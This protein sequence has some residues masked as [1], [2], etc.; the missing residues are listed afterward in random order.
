MIALS[1]VVF[2][3]AVA[4]LASTDRR[5]IRPRIVLSAFAIQV[6]IAVFALY[7]PFGKTVLASLASGVGGIVTYA[8]QGIAFLF[9]PL[10]NDSLGFIF[11]FRVLPVIVFVSA[12]I[13]VLYHLRIMPVIVAVIGGGLKRITGAR[14]IE[15]LSA[16]A[17]IFVGM[18]EAPL[19]VRPYLATLSRS[20]LFSVMAVGLSSVSGA[21][22]LG[23]AAIG[24]DLEYLLPAAFMAAP[25]GLLMAKLLMPESPEDASSPTPV[26]DI[27]AINAE[28]RATNVIEAAG[29]GAMSGLGIAVGVGAMLLAFIA[30]L[31]L[32]NDIFAGLGN[33]VGIS[34]LS[35]EHVLGLLL[36]PVMY[37]MGI[38]WSEAAV[39]GNLLGQKTILNE[40]IA[41]AQLAKIDETLSP[42]SV[43]VITFA[44]CGF[45]NFQALAIIFGGLGAMIPERKKEL[46]QMGM[47]AVLAGTLAN[48]MSAALASLLLTLGAA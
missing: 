20:E 2:L 12:L 1:G 44:L 31:A 45:A 33:L 46:A 19:V 24:I 47:R 36:A 16:A 18:I 41:Y 14:E 42:H 11:A 30:L 3:F 29:N 39:A 15:S 10:G 43:A 32:L 23:Y 5:N 40:F 37:L 13:S 8:D 6:A 26:V 22:L 9:G 48:L 4:V 21:I 17:N 35:L 7:V 27:A 38:P 25:G 34:G 28:T